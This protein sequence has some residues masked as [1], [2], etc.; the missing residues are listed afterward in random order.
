MK[1]KEKKLKASDFCETPIDKKKLKQIL[2]DL[3]YEH[4]FDLS[5]A[6]NIKRL[7]EKINKL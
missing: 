3:L 6:E 5:S 4:N 2:F 7:W 1:K